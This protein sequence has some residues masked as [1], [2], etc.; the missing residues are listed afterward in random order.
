MK[1]NEVIDEMRKANP[2]P[3]TETRGWSESPRGQAVFKEIETEL[4]RGNS[5]NIGPRRLIFRPVAVA[6]AALAL[7]AAVAAVYVTSRPTTDPLSVGCYRELNQSG[8]AA[9]LSLTGSASNLSPAA[10]CAS[11]WESAFGEQVPPNLVTCVVANGG[12]AV[13]PNH[14]NQGAE[15]TCSS[16]GAAP[17]EDGAYAGASAQRVRDWAT[18]LETIYAAAGSGCIDRRELGELVKDSLNDWGLDQWSVSQMESGPGDLNC[19]SY[20]IDA[21]AGA[22]LIVADH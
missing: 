19:A 12:L 15:A 20:S 4:V 10:N 7:L 8:D 21:T 18:D 14:S 17:P 6:S 11:Q 13:F 22:V 2:V 16:I 1:D 5:R 3:A 9:V